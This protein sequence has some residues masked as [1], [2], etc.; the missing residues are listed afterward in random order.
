MEKYFNEIVRHISEIVKFDSSLSPRIGDMPFG[1]GAKDSL[2]YFLD[3]AKK[4]GFETRN[5]D[6][7]V[8]EV[9]FGEGEEI[10]ILA[11]LDVVPATGA[12]EHEPFG[13]E[14]DADRIWGRGTTDDK[15]P[16][17][18]CLFC[19]KA[20]KD[21]GFQPN[22]KIKLIVGCNEESGWKCIEH[23]NKVAHMPEI[24][25]SPDANFPVIY[26]E[27]GILHYTVSYKIENAPFTDLHGGIAANAVCDR[28]EATMNGEK[29][30]AL[31]K[32]AHA[33]MPHLGDNA[34]L[35]LLKRF[36]HPTTNLIV[37]ELFEES[38]GIREMHDETGNLTMSPDV[39]S[40]ENGAL[41][42]TVDVRYPS[43]HSFEEVKSYL[44]KLSG[45]V[46]I[47]SHQPPLF[48]DK[49]SY[50]I[51][52]LTRLYNEEIGE[53]VAPLAIG[54]G[55][56]ARALKCGAGFGPELPGEDYHIHEPNEFI[57]FK[58]IRFCMNLY[59]KTIRELSK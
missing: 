7:Y 2:D 25:F 39:V 47:L 21:E 1:K 28:C 20:L 6:N 14:I 36:D 43:T 11:H 9:I 51:S 41:T 56:Y 27:K 32:S 55:T 37:K 23:Y 30:V 48:N 4:F 15:G 52:T 33:S 54:G 40:Y 17:I 10:A 5:Y 24:G 3:L 45:D 53:N 42:F 44:D 57:S 19:L 49:N 12:W 8:G 59:H 22:K 50:L 13:G 35:K 58:A 29:T 31:G 16:A 26:A 46:K 34:I 18:I 38:Y